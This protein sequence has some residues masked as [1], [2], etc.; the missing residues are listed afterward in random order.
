MLPDRLYFSRKGI[1]GVQASP[2]KRGRFLFLRATV[3]AAAFFHVVAMPEG[4]AE[5]ALG[6]RCH[7]FFRLAR[8]CNEYFDF[9]WR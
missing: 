1:K 8:H 5:Q 2:R 3:S 6:V 7:A 9:G 4:A